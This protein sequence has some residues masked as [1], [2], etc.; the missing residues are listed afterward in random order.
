MVLSFVIM[1]L[2]WILFMSKEHLNHYISV[3]CKFAESSVIKSV[4]DPNEPLLPMT[5]LTRI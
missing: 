5:N 3:C 4:Y 1:L 2:L